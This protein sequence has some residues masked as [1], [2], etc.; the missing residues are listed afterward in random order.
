MRIQPEDTENGTVEISLRWKLPYRA[1][2]KV[3][4]IPETETD[5]LEKRHKQEDQMVPEKLVP[6]IAK[7]KDG[8]Y[9]VVI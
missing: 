2:A 1:P 4:R 5:K 6:H 3:M 7:P 8:K 9:V